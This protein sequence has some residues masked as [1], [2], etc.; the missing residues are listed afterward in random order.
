[1]H[2]R[3]VQDQA[4]QSGPGPPMPILSGTTHS[5]DVRTNPSTAD[6]TTQPC[7][8]R[9]TQ[10]TTVRNHHLTAVC[11]HALTCDPGP[12][13]PVRSG[14]PPSPQWSRPPSPMR[15]GPPSPLP[16]GITQPTAVRDHAST[17][18]SGQGIHVWSRTAHSCVDWD[19]AF[20]CGP[21]RISIRSGTVYF[22]SVRHHACVFGARHANPVRDNTLSCGRGPSDPVRS[23]SPLDPLEVRDHARQCG[24]GPRISLRSG[25]IGLNVRY[26]TMHSRLVQAR[27]VR[28]G[29]AH[30]RESG[31]T[32]ANVVRDHATSYCGP[33]PR[34][35]VRSGTMHSTA[36]IHV[37]MGLD[38]GFHC[39]T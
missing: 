27:H 16:S 19:R 26:G 3:A 10:P 1:M 15:S 14:V 29:T 18:G 20:P 21:R 39:G 9:S 34:V 2:S 35:P 31:I 11:D 37:N 24:P 28:S 22:R 25:T 30:S 13:I 36:V 6:Q 17:C 38:D 33:E 4:C 32:H 12:C 5:A 8:V 7:V 23:R